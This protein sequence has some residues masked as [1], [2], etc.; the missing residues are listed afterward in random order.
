M[1]PAPPV[2]R[3]CFDFISGSA[4]RSS[5]GRHASR[6]RVA[7]TP[8]DLDN[9]GYLACERVRPE[10]P[11]LERRASVDT[12]RPAFRIVGRAL[13][14]K[15]STPPQGVWC[16]WLGSASHGRARGQTRAG[17]GAGMARIARSS[18]KRRVVSRGLPGSS[19]VR[20]SSPFGL[21]SQALRGHTSR[22]DPSRPRAG[23]AGVRLRPLGGMPLRPACRVNVSRR[24]P[25]DTHRPRQQERVENLDV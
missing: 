24:L 1:N 20:D 16:G 13:I 25:R 23:D 10:T 22:F 11:G 3:Q 14:R 17:R 21:A 2:T 6:C 18:E 12:R 9:E 15:I 7:R 19:R 8:V 4:D 5:P